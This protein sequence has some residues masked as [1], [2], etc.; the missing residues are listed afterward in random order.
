MQWR[1]ETWQKLRERL[2]CPQVP[3]TQGHKHVWC[4]AQSFAWS[5]CELIDV[6]RVPRTAYGYFN[7]ERFRHSG[8]CRNGKF[9]ISQ[10]RTSCKDCIHVVCFPNASG[11]VPLYKRGSGLARFTS[12]RM[13][14]WTCMKAFKS[15]CVVLWHHTAGECRLHEISMLLPF[16]FKTMWVMQ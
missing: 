14:V 12:R 5:L 8:R 4:Y 16:W 13:I 2:F 1:P 6:A 9:V 15:I 11:R 3:G 10:R 7:L